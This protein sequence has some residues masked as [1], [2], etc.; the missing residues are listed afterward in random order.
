M[1]VPGPVK[2]SS[3]DLLTSFLY[4]ADATPPE[5]WEQATALYRFFDR[6]GQLLYLGITRRLRIRMT[7]HARDYAETWWPLVSSRTVSWYE[8][9][10]QAWRTERDA[11]RT[12]NPPYNVMHT[13]RAR[14]PLQA[15]PSR[16]YGE[17]GIPLLRLAQQ[18]FD[19]QPFTAADAIGVAGCSSATVQQWIRSLSHRGWLVRVGTRYCVSIHKGVPIRQHALW[20][21]PDS[22]AGR[23]GLLVNQC[24]DVSESTRPP[25]PRAPESGRAKRPGGRSKWDRIYPD[26]REA[27]LLRLAEKTFGDR[28]FTCSQLATAD[29]KL[30]QTI[31]KYIRKLRASGSIQEVGREENLTR[32]G[33]PAI[34]YAVCSP[35]PSA[36]SPH[37]ILRTAEATA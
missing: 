28:P 32:A 20:A 24:I 37:M 29:G 12:E 30:P 14:V 10:S 2:R 19:S 5:E 11:I 34:Q 8:T 4:N 26:G 13:A 31:T 3:D 25:G 9:R 6:Q 15:R 36:S 21:S 35:R 18:E 17:R 22:E 23:S 16:D 27:D 1:T 33:Y 7:E